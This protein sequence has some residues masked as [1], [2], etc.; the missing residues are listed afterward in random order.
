[1]V[2]IPHKTL[3][4]TSLL[5]AILP[6]CCNSTLLPCTTP[7]LPL[8]HTG[9]NMCLASW[10]LPLPAGA[11]LH[12]TCLH[13]RRRKRRRR[14]RRRRDWDACGT[15]RRRRRAAGGGVA[16]GGGGGVAE[17]VAVAG[18]PAFD[19]SSAAATA[20]PAL[21]VRVVVRGDSLCLV[22]SAVCA[23]GTCEPLPYSGT[24]GGRRAA[25]MEVLRSLLRH[26]PFAGIVLTARVD[27]RR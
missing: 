18:A 14:R 25:R 10:L 6:F 21:L 17:P 12:T 22:L 8:L 3:H 27:G 4:I 2:N 7:F 20:S 16:G 23:G 11:W 9:E 15:V 26:L 24:S 13:G 1:M 19:S 5:P